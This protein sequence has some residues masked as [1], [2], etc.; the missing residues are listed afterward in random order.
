LP[1][2]R[3][4]AGAQTTNDSRR[5][6]LLFDHNLFYRS[7]PTVASLYP[8]SMDVRD[9][10]MT[11]ADDEEIWSFA[12][13]QGLTIVSKDTDFYQRSI[14]FGHPPKMVWIRLGNCTTAQVEALLR[15]RHADLLAFDQD[16]NA[17]FLALA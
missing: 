9:V 16:A 6:N 8:G 14:F 12:R 4:R 13:Q 3:R 2:L 7:V 10:G 17:S 11:A 5:M 1:G 15:T